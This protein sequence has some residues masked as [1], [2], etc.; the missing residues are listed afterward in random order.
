LDSL[1]LA[2]TN[3]GSFAL[4]YL[5]TKRTLTIDLTKLSG[6]RIVASWSNPR[7][8]DTTPIG[9]FTDKKR[10]AFEPPGDGGWV[11]VLDGTATKANKL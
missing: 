10:H 9:E 1:A 8:G 3:D 7:T 11:L 5:P 4:S 2:L 6:E